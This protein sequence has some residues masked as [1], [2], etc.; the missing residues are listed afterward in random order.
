MIDAVIIIF[1]MILLIVG[2]S[3]LGFVFRHLLFGMW[4]EPVLRVPVLLFESDDW[5]PGNRQQAR[6]LERL[7][8][9]LQSYQDAKGSN[10]VMTLGV[11][12]GLPDTEKNRACSLSA[13]HRVNLAEPRF[14]E[15]REAMQRGVEA[16][17]FSLQ[18]HGLE[19]YWP[20]A[21]LAAAKQDQA[22][23]EW[24]TG[25]PLPDTERLPPA[26]QSRW[27]DGSCLPSR[28]LNEQEVEQAA[29]E[30]VEMFA[31]I[32]GYTPAVLVP[33]TF[34]WSPAVERGW[35]AAGGRIVVTPGQRYEARDAENKLL[36]SGPPIRN[37]DKSP[38][39]MSYIVRSDYFEPAYGHTAERALHA[40]ARKNR[41]ARPTLLEIHRCNFTQDPE[42]AEC[43]LSEL[44][45]LLD[46]VLK[47]Y[48]DVTFLSAE[49]IAQAFN[50]GDPTLLEDRYFRRLYVWLLRWRDVPRLW[51]WAK[52]TGFAA[53]IVMLQLVLG[54]DDY[55][56]SSL[57]AA[58]DGQK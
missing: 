49:A 38:T 52:L 48:P 4:H 6:Q 31:A 27:I 14:Q 44:R 53:V 54:R 1:I 25:D 34:V 32:F 11:V 45:R 15:I 35:A 39:G 2:W 57:I 17:V 12:L 46:E 19:H 16:G 20:A 22:I 55:A 8:G 42:L 18:L 51:A 58:P 7:M 41:T 9:L 23:R 40:M 3:L 47:R 5:G 13:F 37:G 24:L 28:S 21:L 29:R 36:P 50:R 30:E 10:P 56:N 33:P 43:S 26:L